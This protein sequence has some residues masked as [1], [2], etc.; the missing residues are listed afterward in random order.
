MQSSE[1]YD[2]IRYPGRVYEFT[3]PDRLATIA[4]LHG[5][6]AP[7]VETARV[8][9][10]GCGDGTNLLGIAASLPH[11]HLLGIDRCADPLSD[12]RSAAAG[13][14]LHHVEFHAMDVEGLLADGPSFDYIIVHGMLSWV[15]DAT[16]RAIMAVLAARLSPTGVAMVSYNALPGWRFRTIARDIILAGFGRHPEPHELAQARDLIHIF[17][18]ELS[19]SGLYGAVVSELAVFVDDCTDAALYHDLLSPSCDPLDFRSFAALYAPAGLEY[20]ADVVWAD[21][22]V[23]GYPT[24][25]RERLAPL[26]EDPVAR[27][28]L[29]DV[30]RNTLFRRPLLCRASARSDTARPYSLDGLYVTLCSEPAGSTADGDQ[31]R[32]IDGLVVTVSNPA[33]RAGLR[34]LVAVA[35][36]AL[37]VEVLLSGEGHP[38]RRHT[39]ALA[40]LVLQTWAGGLIELLPRQRRHSGPA[41]DLPT[42]YPLARWQAERGS[43]TAINCCHEQIDLNAIDRC[44]LRLCDGHRTREELVLALLAAA[45]SGEFNI[46]SD[47]VVA[48]DPEVRRRAIRGGLEVRLRQLRTAGLLAI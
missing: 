5:I 9:E 10:I 48:R 27:E 17:A 22:V 30:M 19:G 3:H 23:S 37:P 2:A 18:K 12:A 29:V 36:N 16:K 45:D 14:D 24:S 21:N 41:G 46:V 43:N 20:V 31:F 35:P 6:G 26:A 42:A 33:L 39:D 7:E 34:H 40:G 1:R 32:T 11:A 8:L 15:P 4:R 38:D 44:M 13:L 47:D 28:Q 25:F